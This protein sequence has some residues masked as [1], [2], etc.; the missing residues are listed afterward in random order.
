LKEGF[1]KALSQSVEIYTVIIFKNNGKTQ[2]TNVHIV[3]DLSNLSHVKVLESNEFLLKKSELLDLEDIQYG[4]ATS[5]KQKS[6]FQMS[7]LK[8]EPTD[9]RFLILKTKGG[10]P[11]KGNFSIK[12]DLFELPDRFAIYIIFGLCLIFTIIIVVFDYLI[13]KESI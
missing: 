6:T 8:L 5:Q 2:A 3:A 10:S 7:I 1:Y 12:Y 9:F 13:T 4:I 11:G